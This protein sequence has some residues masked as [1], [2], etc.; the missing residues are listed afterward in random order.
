[1]TQVQQPSTPSTGTKTGHYVIGS[2]AILAVLA[3]IGWFLLSRGRP[4]TTTEIPIA[5]K[6]VTTSTATSTPKKDISSAPTASTSVATPL[7]SD[8]KKLAD[9][10][11]KKNGGVEYYYCNDLHCFRFSA[12][13]IAPD[14]KMGTW[15]RDAATAAG[16]EDLTLQVITHV[17]LFSKDGKSFSSSLVEFNGKGRE[18]EVLTGAAVLI[19]DGY[20]AEE[21]AGWAKRTNETLAVITTAPPSTLVTLLPASTPAAPIVQTRPLF[22]ISE[23]R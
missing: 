3:F 17:T 14:N 6:T 13:R 23:T 15:V 16:K 10:G 18:G 19:R 5:T 20:S 2:L 8:L 11:A 9:L 4:T 22:E 7:A 1:M 21:V 12:N